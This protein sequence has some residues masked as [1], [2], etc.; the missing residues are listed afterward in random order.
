MRTTAEVRAEIEAQ[1]VLQPGEPGWWEV[2]GASPQDVRTGDY[3]LF[4]D[5]EE[6]YIQYAE[7]A[8]N[9]WQ[10]RYQRDGEWYRMGLGCRLVLLRRGTRHT[11]SDTVR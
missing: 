6:M 1:G 7:R 5:G 11:L 3:L 2:W 10:V 9:G 4:G 8:S